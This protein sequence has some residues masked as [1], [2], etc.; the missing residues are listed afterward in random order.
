MLPQCSAPFVCRPHTYTTKDEG[1]KCCIDYFLAW[2]RI[3]F[4]PKSVQSEAGIFI[5]NEDNDHFPIVARARIEASNTTHTVFKRR[6]TPYDKSKIG[7][8]Q[9]D[10]VLIEHM[11]NYVGV[12]CAVEDSSHLHILDEAVVSA[13]G[14][15][16]PKDKK[17][18]P[19]NLTDFTKN[20][21][22]DRNA[23]FHKQCV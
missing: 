10:K 7:N 8:I 19:K 6:N 13:M 5:G 11:K 12:P 4:K 22:L 2:G 21:V 1:S 3:T 18:N 9:C 16:Y 20:A 15:A 17:P 23:D 14:I